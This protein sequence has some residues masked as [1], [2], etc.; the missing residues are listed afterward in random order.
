M[1]TDTSIQKGQTKILF[2][3]KDSH[4]NNMYQQAKFFFIVSDNNIIVERFINFSY[5]NKI[6]R[7]PLYKGTLDISESLSH[8]IVYLQVII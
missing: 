5:I 6:G 8:N 3:I 4:E 2:T 1:A 7:V